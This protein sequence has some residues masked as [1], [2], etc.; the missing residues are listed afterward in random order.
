MAFHS[1]NYIVQI[2]MPELLDLSSLRSG[3]LQPNETLMADTA[4]PAA[5]VI[6]E[7]AAVVS[8]LV[9]M[10][11]PA[12][13]CRRAV[14]LTQ[15][16]GLEAA[17]AWVMEHMD[18]PDFSSPFPPPAAASAAAAVVAISEEN[19]AMVMSMGFGLEQAQ[20]ALRNTD[21]NV[22]RAVEWI[23]SHPEG[24]EAAT[25]PPAST[26]AAASG[27]Q[28]NAVQAGLSDGA[29]RYL[30]IPYRTVPYLIFQGFSLA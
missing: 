22:E 13:A 2:E 27:Q 29:P 11:F 15:D 7:N 14:H 8:Q 25:Q 4:T 19:V 9:E 21:N 26:A 16:A 5:A 6:H 24:E 10:G 12:D 3:G 1:V 20:A 28:A 30:R 17:M 23:F 18:D